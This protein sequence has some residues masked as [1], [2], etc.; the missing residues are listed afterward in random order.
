MEN[1]IFITHLSSLYII[2]LYNEIAKKNNVFVNI[3][4]AIMLWVGNTVFLFI[5]NNTSIV[6]D[7]IREGLVCQTFTITN[8]A[9][10]DTFRKVK[11]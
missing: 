4:C 7:K 8:V 6:G 10:Y 11:I 5:A 2:R 1:I 9:S 3:S